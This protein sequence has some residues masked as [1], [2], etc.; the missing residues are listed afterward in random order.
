MK[1]ETGPVTLQ[2]IGPRGVHSRRALI[3]A[4]ASAGS[5]SILAAC[6]QSTGGGAEKQASKPQAG[7]VSL[8]IWS[9]SM[10]PPQTTAQEQVHKDFQEKYPNV[11]LKLTQIPGGWDP[12]VEK[13]QISIT[14]N[15]QP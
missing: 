5:V 1:R 11:T 9:P 2:T 6:G 10:A 13:L 14:G 7:P 8:E 3:R 4:A 15:V 12:V